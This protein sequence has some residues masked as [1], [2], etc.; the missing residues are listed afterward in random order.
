MPDPHRAGRRSSANTRCIMCQSCGCSR[1]ARGER[2]GDALH[3]RDQPA[4]RRRRAAPAA[5]NVMRHA[6]RPR[7][8]A[9]PAPAAP[10]C[11]GPAAPGPRGI[12]AA[13]RRSSVDLDAGAGQVAVG[14]QAHQPPAA[15]PL[16]EPR[17]RAPRRRSAAG[18][19]CRAWCGRRRTRRRAARAS[20]APRPSHSGIP[21]AHA[22]APAQSQLAMCGRATTTPR[23]LRV[24]VAHVVLVDGPG[25][26]YDVVDRPRGQPER[27]APVAQVGAHRLVRQRVER[28]VVE[29]GPHPGRFARSRCTP[30]PS[31]R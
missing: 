23:P 6:R 10:R 30:A 13:L 31:R 19:P 22:Q 14:E 29:L 3:H 24:G 12:R 4:R 16:L 5:W 26:S 1:S 15:H 21:V 17:Q 9:S 27:L 25:A 28:V 8:A 7:S 11:G 20:A 2:V 18:S